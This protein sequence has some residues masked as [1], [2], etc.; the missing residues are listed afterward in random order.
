MAFFFGKFFEGFSDFAS[1]KIDG[2]TFMHKS[3]SSFYA[4][5]AIGAATFL[6]KG[7]L[8]SLWLVFGE[9]QARSVRELLFASLL[10]REIEWY[11]ARTSG[12]G[13]LLTK[14]QR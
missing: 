5:F 13:P 2:N 7:S 11:E 3:L 9:I 6:L 4:L 10:D 1:G 12:V 14:I 8:F